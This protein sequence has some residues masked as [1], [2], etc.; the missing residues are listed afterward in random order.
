[1]QSCHKKLK[2]KAF[3]KQL[4][5]KIA[6]AVWKYMQIKS[7]EADKVMLLRTCCKWLQVKALKIVKVSKTCHADKIIK[8]C[9]C[10]DCILEPLAC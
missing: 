6:H 1:M 9:S 4:I 10:C 5:V 3:K 2:V 7:K 8:L